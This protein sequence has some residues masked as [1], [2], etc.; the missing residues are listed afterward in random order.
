METCM[1]WRSRGLASAGELG[2]HTQTMG[3]CRNTRGGLCTWDG[4]LGALPQNKNPHLEIFQSCHEFSALTSCLLPP[5]CPLASPTG[6]LARP[7]RRE[8]LCHAAQS[9]STLP[10]I[11][12]PSVLPPASHTRLHF[13]L[14]LQSNGTC[15]RRPKSGKKNLISS[16]CEVGEAVREKAARGGDAPDANPVVPVLERG[17]G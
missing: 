1:G 16:C 9:T 13:S 5:C 6:T 7:Q 12:L 14:Y 2:C 3:F 4:L 11:Q 8:Y 17:W 10:A 15:R